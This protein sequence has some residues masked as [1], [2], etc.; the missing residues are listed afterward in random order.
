[1]ISKNKI[2]EIA[3]NNNKKLGEKAYKYLEK[4]VKIMIKETLDNAS[5]NADFEGRKIIKEEDLNQNA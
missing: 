3:R 5:I 2:K 4:K 1:M